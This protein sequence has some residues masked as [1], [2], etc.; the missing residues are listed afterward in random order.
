[1]NVKVLY[2]AALRD[3]LDCGEET[4]ELPKSVATIGELRDYLAAR[5]AQW[6]PL[7]G[8]KNVRMARNQRIVTADEPVSEND[9]IA[10]FPPVTGG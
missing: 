8:T 10:F 7:T 3:A 6:A 2:F 9:E 5:G 1:M 4:V